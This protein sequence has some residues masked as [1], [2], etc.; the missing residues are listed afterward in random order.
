MNKNDKVS[1]EIA[2]GGSLG[3]MTIEGRD[4][5]VRPLKIKEIRAVDSAGD[6]LGAQFGVMTDI[7]NRR[8][9]GEPISQD[10]LEESLD[11]EGYQK[12]VKM[13]TDPL[14]YSEDDPKA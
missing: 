13:L 5:D 7:L 3:T 14:N 6:E 11:V 4:F 2:T 10:W 8:V 12:L 1:F 9:R